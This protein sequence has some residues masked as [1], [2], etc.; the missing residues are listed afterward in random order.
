MT[1]YRPV[2]SPLNKTNGFYINPASLDIPHCDNIVIFGDN[3]LDFSLGLLNARTSLSVTVTEQNILYSSFWRL[4]KATG[5]K[6]FIEH[7]IFE[8]PFMRY[9]KHQELLE[10]MLDLE[11]A[12]AMLCFFYLTVASSDGTPFSSP[13][14]LSKEK[15]FLY[16]NKLK[17]I[18]NL[19]PR[20][21]FTDDLNDPGIHLCLSETD[22]NF[23][24]RDLDTLC[25]KLEQVPLDGKSIIL[26]NLPFHGL[27]QRED[28]NRNIYYTNV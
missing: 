23:F 20:I 13:K 3:D 16:L 2:M 5:V 14:N 9:A 10:T 1:V 12:K 18:E 7:F 6:E 27:R 28:L 8:L 4:V 21:D 25:Q 26:S 22:R 11:D 24:N 15:L 19:I 17:T